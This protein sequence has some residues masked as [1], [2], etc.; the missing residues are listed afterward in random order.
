VCVCWILTSNAKHMIG[1]A[2]R[3]PKLSFG[4]LVNH[5]RNSL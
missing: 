3:S 5:N 2:A 1:S 4:A